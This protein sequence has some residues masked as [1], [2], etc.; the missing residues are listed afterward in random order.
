MH[1]KITLGIV[2]VE[3]GKERFDSR[4]A[5][6]MFAGSFARDIRIA[7][8]ALSGLENITMKN[9][10]KVLVALPFVTLSAMTG[11]AEN[12]PPVGPFTATLQAPSGKCSPSQYPFIC[13]L[14][15]SGAIGP[16]SADLHIVWHNPGAHSQYDIPADIHTT[17]ET[18]P[19]SGGKI[20][21]SFV[22]PKLSGSLAYASEKPRY[23]VLTPHAG[24]YAV[25]LFNPALPSPEVSM[26]EGSIGNK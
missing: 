17:V 25:S 18:I 10:R 7:S 3:V 23:F 22:L 19:N 21:L 26:G 12:A 13:A 2:T 15:L 6:L 5:D 16:Q 4:G 9:V 20:K 14:D 8:I 11:R 1:I 24:G